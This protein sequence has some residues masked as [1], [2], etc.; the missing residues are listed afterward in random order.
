MA[1][2]DLSD[3]EIPTHKYHQTKGGKNL[4]PRWWTVEESAIH[5]HLFPLVRDIE[6]RQ[7][8]RRAANL[9]HARLYHNMEVLGFYAGVN[10]PTVFE[11]FNSARISINVVK[12]CIDTACSKLA[13]SKPR[14]IF[15]TDGGNWDQ[16]ERAKDLTKFLDG[17]FS[18]MEYYAAKRKA[19][20][21]AMIF[22]TGAIKFYKEGGQVH[23]ERALI[24]EIIIDD[25]EAIY[26]EPQSLHQVRY[27]SRDKLKEAF[28][29]HEAAIK[30]AAPGFSANV[31]SPGAKDIIRIV[32]SWHLKSGPDADDGAHAIVID[33]CTLFAEKYTRDFFPFEFIRWT[34]RVTGFFGI[35]IAEEL[36]GIQ[37]E[38]NKLF[39][40]IQKAQ[41]L[42]CVPRVWFQAGSVSNKNLTNEIGY[43]GTYDGAPPMFTTAPAMPPEAYQHANTLYNRAFEIVGISALSATAQKPAGLDSGRALRE[44]QD[45]ES[46]R[47][48]IF[49]QRYDDGA[50]LAAKITIEMTQELAEDDPHYAIKAEDGKSIEELRWKDVNLERDQ[51]VMR[52]FPSNILPATPAG[53]LQT[54]QELVQA[55]FIDRENALDLLDFPDLEAFMGYKN[56][57]VEMVKKIIYRI[58]KEGEYQTPEPYM[59]LT[60]AQQMAQLAYLKAKNDNVPEE[61]LDLFRRFIDDCAALQ[62]Q[63]QAP[64]Q[65]PAAMMAQAGLGPQP[66]LEGQPMAAPEAMPTNELIPNVPGAV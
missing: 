34:E 48:Q 62:Q 61:R 64:Q 37:I 49:S 60:V 18:A 24:D 38:L 15:L 53:R 50:L 32:E 33:G 17:S 47:F 28:P 35:G 55:G 42:M 8:Y 12:A 16:Q 13:K 46:E 1:R 20:R 57:P 26:G 31:T 41:H 30:E 7:L 65:D 29:K 25:A 3:K 58:L 39:R 40:T 14:P 36:T 9:R 43:V 63:M 5:E 19:A 4:E 10:N 45:I 44:Y 66:G 59:N 21:D 54:I 6:R 27:V 22:G 51:Y 52:C 2:H 11:P 56:A 23:C